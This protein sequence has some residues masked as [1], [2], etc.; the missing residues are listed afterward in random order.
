VRGHSEIVS[1]NRSGERT[2]A[3]NVVAA[4]PNR[5]ACS[6][7]TG[8]SAVTVRSIATI[9]S[10]NRLPGA[11]SVCITRS[12]FGSRTGSVP[13]VSLRSAPRPANPSP[14]PPSTCRTPVLVRESKT[15]VTSSIC[16]GT[17]ACAVGTVAPSA[18]TSR[19]SPPSMSTY[20]MPS[21]LRAR[22][23][24][25]ES[26]GM[27]PLS[28]SSLT[29]TRATVRPSTSCVSTSLT[30]PIRKPPRRTS[31]P[32]VTIAPSGSSTYSVFVGTKGSPSFAL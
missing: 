23:V 5:C 27:S 17:E 6:R 7:A 21:R 4:T 26:T 25:R 3:A 11:A 2:N 15:P 16:T 22:T 13:N 10:P 14:S 30:A 1:R 24:K 29:V 19:D 9:S 20:L 31:L 12:S 28:S 8:S 18:N 32:F